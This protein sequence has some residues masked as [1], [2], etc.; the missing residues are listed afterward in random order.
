ML[1]PIHKTKDKKFRFR[2][3]LPLAQTVSGLGRHETKMQHHI[4]IV[5]EKEHVFF[6]EILK[7]FNMNVWPFFLEYV[8]CSET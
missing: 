4:S 7:K 1:L 5:L 2:G 3:K 8:H 6:P